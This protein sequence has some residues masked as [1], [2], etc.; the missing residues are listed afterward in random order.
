[1]I[2]SKF[3]SLLKCLSSSMLLRSCVRVS[4]VTKYFVLLT[5]EY[6]ASCEAYRVKFVKIKSLITLNIQCVLF[7][8]YSTLLLILGL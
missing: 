3:S 8:A 7:K 6:R 4:H 1:M 2:A 5:L